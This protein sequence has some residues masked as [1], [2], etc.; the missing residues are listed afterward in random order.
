MF[1]VRLNFC[2]VNLC[3]V[4]IV[5]S[6][7]ICKVGEMWLDGGKEDRKLGDLLTKMDFVNWKIW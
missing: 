5:I 7:Y 3:V 1:G 6:Y 4:Y 2:G